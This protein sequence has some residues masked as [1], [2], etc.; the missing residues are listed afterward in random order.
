M[1]HVIIGT[2]AFQSLKKYNEAI[3]RQRFDILLSVILNSD[4]CARSST[5]PKAFGMTSDH[6]ASNISLNKF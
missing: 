3:G 6:Q 5:V 4:K 1:I 2:T